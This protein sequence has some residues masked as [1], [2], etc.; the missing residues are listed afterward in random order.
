VD[1]T[2]RFRGPGPRFGPYH[3]DPR[4]G[5]TGAE[6]VRDGAGGPEELFHCVADGNLMN[7]ALPAGDV[8]RFETPRPLLKANSMGEVTADSE[9]FLF[10]DS[11]AKSAPGPFTA[12]K[13]LAGKGLATLRRNIICCSFS[14]APHTQKSR[15]HIQSVGVVGR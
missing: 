8:F 11:M 10:P 5:R 13:N 9:R 15:P 12:P 2:C 6:A 1:A 4:P 7:M 3:I 14:D